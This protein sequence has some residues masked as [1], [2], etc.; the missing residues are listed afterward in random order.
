MVIMSLNC[1]VGHGAIA[2][3]ASRKEWDPK[4]LIFGVRVVHIPV[5]LVQGKGHRDLIWLM[6][7]NV[8]PLLQTIQMVWLGLVSGPGP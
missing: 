7:H 2:M 3:K 6:G 4:N 8:H 5:P 1:G